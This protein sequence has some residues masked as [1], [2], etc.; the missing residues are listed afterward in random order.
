MESL[1]TKKYF[2]RDGLITVCSIASVKLGSVSVN[3]MLE[4]LGKK[5]FLKTGFTLATVDGPHH[6]YGT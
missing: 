2:S 1:G 5:R 4:D 6:R 3:S